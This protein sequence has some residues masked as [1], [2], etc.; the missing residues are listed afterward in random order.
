MKKLKDISIKYKI[1]ALALILSTIPVAIIGIYAYNEVKTALYTEIQGKLEEQVRLENDY[2]NVTLTLA[3]DKVDSDLGVAR[4]QFYEKGTPRVADGKMVLGDNYVVNGNFEIVDTIKSMVGGTATVFQVT[5]SEAIRISTNVIQN[6]STRAVGTK[7]SQPVYDAVVTRGETYYGRAWV[8]NAWYLTAYEPIKDRSGKIIGILYVGVLEDPFINNIKRQMKS[9]VV[10]KTGYLYV[11]DSKGNL[12]IHPNREGENIYEYDFIKTI[13]ETKKGFIQYPWEGKDKVVAYT[14]YE[15][16]DWIIASGSYLDDFS[17]PIYAIRDSLILTVLVFFVSGSVLGIWFSRSITRPIE[18]MLRISNK[19]A[20]GDLTV[21]VRSTTKDEIGQLFAAIQAMTENLKEVIGKLQGSAL[22]VSSAAQG[23][24]TSSE[25]MK[26]ATEQVSTTS[27]DIAKGVSHQASKM[28]EISRTMK[29]MADSVQQVAANSQK[30]A[31]GAQDANKTA[32]EVGGMSSEIARKMAEIQKTVDDSAVVIKELDSKSLKIGE[33]IGVITNIADQTNLLALNAAIEAARAGEHG[34]GFAVV[35]DEV[36]KLAE[37]SRSA[38]NQITLLIKEVQLG[39]KQ[40]VE[41]MERGTKTVNEGAG[42]IE[43]AVSAIN[44]VVKAAGDVSNMIQ[45]IAATA[46]EQSASVEEVTSSIEDVSAI[47]QESA[48]GTEE[49]SAA[50]E[51][52]TA[53]MEQLVRAA[54]ELTVLSEDLQMV[55]SRFILK[56]AKEYIRCWDIKEC[57]DDIRQKCPAY[58]SPETRCWLIEGTW[59]GGIRQG[60]A[61]AKMH[62]CM[63]CEAFKRNT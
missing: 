55:A 45:E 3:Q 62:N 30:A 5:G 46:E 40:A 18:A 2:I 59:C 13:T 32:Q 58:K 31:E 56:S 51:E 35:A 44:R 54:Q 21:R 1:I 37:E 60:D 61:K 36:R 25:E 15:P 8:V 6:D 16:R 39:T 12:V 34:R 4:N 10:G 63:T 24:S 11:I 57:K 29:E 20:A 38:A 19:V 14:Y 41:S 53:S 22:K 52:Q 7:V 48:A 43:N 27:Q 9:M 26:A 28:A 17:G 50:T 33:I 47:S 49:A 42:T 23:L